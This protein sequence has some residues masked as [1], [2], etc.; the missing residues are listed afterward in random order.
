MQPGHHPQTHPA[1]GVKATSQTH[2]VRSTPSFGTLFETVGRPDLQ[3]FVASAYYVIAHAYGSEEDL[4]RDLAACTDAAWSV[5]SWFSVFGVC[6]K[7]AGI[8]LVKTNTG[9]ADFTDGYARVSCCPHDKVLLLLMLLF[10]VDTCWA[11]G[12]PEGGP[13]PVKVYVAALRFALARRFPAS[14]F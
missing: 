4:E 14:R 11:D 12:V 5:S 13:E 2:V 9:A 1:R 8:V 3:W 6:V 10:G 7:Q